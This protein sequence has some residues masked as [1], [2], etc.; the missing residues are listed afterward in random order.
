MGLKVFLALFAFSLCGAG[1][2]FGTEDYQEKNHRKLS[3]T[4]SNQVINTNTQNTFN[5][6]YRMLNTNLWQYLK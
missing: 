5:L 3:Q 2:T 1:L 4:Y 6:R